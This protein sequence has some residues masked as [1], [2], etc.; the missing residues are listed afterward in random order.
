M[1]KYTPRCAPFR[2]RVWHTPEKSKSTLLARERRIRGQVEALERA[3][4]TD[5]ECADVLQPIAA[6]CGAINS[7]MNQVVEG[8]VATQRS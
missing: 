1:K 7:L 5:P 6:V 2:D 3:L 8:L 4:N